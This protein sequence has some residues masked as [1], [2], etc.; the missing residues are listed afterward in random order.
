M[1]INMAINKGIAKLRKYYLKTRALNLR[2][3]VLY[4]SLIFDPRIKN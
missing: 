2:N 3:K 4:L 1:T